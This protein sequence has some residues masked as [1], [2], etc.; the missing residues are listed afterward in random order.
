MGLLVIGMMTVSKVTVGKRR[1]TRH[2]TVHD[3]NGELLHHTEA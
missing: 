3:W 2:R 1:G